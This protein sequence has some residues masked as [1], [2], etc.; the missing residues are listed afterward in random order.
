[1]S[2]RAPGLDL[3]RDEE[4]TPE[5][6]AV[7]EGR[8]DIE[9][10]ADLVGADLEAEAVPSA[11]APAE[12]AAEL[13]EAADGRVAAGPIPS[14]VTPVSAEEEREAGAL[15]VRIGRMPVAARIK[16][17]LAGNRSARQVLGR[18][19]LRLVQRCLLANPRITQE[20]VLA[21]AKNRSQHGEIL[22]IIGA[23]R[24]WVRHYPIRVA[25]VLNPKTPLPVSLRLLGGVV[26]RD[27]R[28]IAR[29]RNVPTAIQAQARRVI[30]RRGPG[31]A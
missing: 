31:G 5:I 21:F 28:T 4:R 13:L 20:E 22:R 25:L 10:D 11:V 18:D 27:M 1:M 7:L 3:A 15:W 8:D 12:G 24:D 29:S 19:P 9:L 16:L 6:D 14:P 2:G 23:Q 17:A 30:L 26:D